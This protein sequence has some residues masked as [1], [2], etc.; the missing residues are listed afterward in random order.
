[1]RLVCDGDYQLPSDAAELRRSL[2]KPG[3]EEA[4]ESSDTVL[5]DQ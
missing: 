3:I 1:M 2:W 5:A 4:V